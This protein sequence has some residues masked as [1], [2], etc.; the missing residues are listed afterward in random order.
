MNNRIIV[1]HKTKI[2]VGHI[3]S[4]KNVFNESYQDQKKSPNIEAFSPH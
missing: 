3:K 4:V 2:Q 1:R